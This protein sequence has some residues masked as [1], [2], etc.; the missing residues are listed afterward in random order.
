[1]AR[2]QKGEDTN[3]SVSRFSPQAVRGALHTTGPG[4]GGKTVAMVMRE[5]RQSEGVQEPGNKWEVGFLRVGG[6]G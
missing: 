1:M 2:R 5:P 6:R 3:K 4:K